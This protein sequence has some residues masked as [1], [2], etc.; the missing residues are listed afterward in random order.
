MK[1]NIFKRVATAAAMVAITGLAFFAGISKGSAGKIDPEKGDY[2]NLNGVNGW[3]IDGNTLEIVVN[4]HSY[5][6]DK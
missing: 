5:I 2:I 6:I 4:G 3:N 1:R